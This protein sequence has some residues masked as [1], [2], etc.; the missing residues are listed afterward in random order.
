MFPMTKQMWPFLVSCNKLLDYQPVIAPDFMVEAKMSGLLTRWT[1]VN[2]GLT[3]SL[4]LTSVPKSKLGQ[5]TVIYRAVLAKKGDIQYRDSVGRPILWI[6]GIVIKGNAQKSDIPSNILEKAFESVEKEYEAFWEGSTV[7]K[8][9]RPINVADFFPKKGG[10]KS[11]FML[12][13]GLATIFIILIPVFGLLLIFLSLGVPLGI[14]L[15]P[16]SAVLL[17]LMADILF[18]VIVTAIAMSEYRKL[19]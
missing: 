7:I 8:K 14:G 2:E 18:S 3:N 12:F 9:S 19:K 11:K 4:L 17:L 10:S 13:T 6:E 15:P 5:I 16:F 1:P